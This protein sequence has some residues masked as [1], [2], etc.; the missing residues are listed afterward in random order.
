MNKEKTPKIDAIESVKEEIIKY[1]NSPKYKPQ[2]L[3]G[4]AS[5][6][7]YDRFS[8]RQAISELTEEGVILWGKKNCYFLPQSL[9]WRRGKIQGHPRGYGFFLPEGEGEDIFISPG[10]LNGAWHGDTVWLKPKELKSRRQAEERRQRGQVAFIIKR[11]HGLILGQYEKR[12]RAGIVYPLEKRINQ[13][14]FIR[15]GQGKR[16]KDGD[17]VLAEIDTWPEEGRSPAYGK[18]KEIITHL[19]QKKGDTLITVKKFGL[20][21]EFAPNVLLA[22]QKAAK[23]GLG[24]LEQLKNREDLREEFILTIDGLDARDL[25]DALS[26]TKTKDGNR[27]LGVHIADVAHYVPLNSPLDKEAKERGT[28]VYFPNLVLPMLPPELS[29]GICSLN[30]NEDRLALSCIMEINPKGEIINHRL[31][32]SIIRV[33]HRLC[34]EDINAALE[35]DNQ[36]ALEVLAPCLNMLRDLW[37]LR[38]ALLQRRKAKGSLNFE[39]P[40]CKVIMNEEDEI[41]EVKKQ[42]SRLGESLIEEAMLAANQTVAEAF[43]RLKLPFIYRVHQPCQGDKLFELNESLKM[44]NYYLPGKGGKPNSKDMQELLNKVKGKPE[45]RLVSTLLLRSMDHAFYSTEP[46]GHFALAF[47]YY[48]H[49]TAPIRR[50]PDLAIHRQIKAWL[51]GEKSGGTEEGL[52]FIASHSSGRERLAEKAEREITAI[53]CCRYLED[54]IGECFWGN[55]SGITSYGLY[56]E[57]DTGIE[58]LVRIGDIEDDYYIFYEKE[59]CLKGKKGKTYRLGDRVKVSIARVDA[60]LITIDLFLMPEEAENSC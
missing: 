44:L 60:S 21:A 37:A 39:F 27:L 31:T 59:Y 26:L 17:T 10:D 47:E 38:D 9:G 52:A 5:A 57:M 36:Q 14:I 22:A 12:N 32:E 29:N 20:E 48:S 13:P 55:I 11:A 16:A 18:I 53:L 51:I 4:L 23:N 1:F 6:L 8:L 41:I 30:V 2:N 46:L 24:G 25:D 56:V 50:Y 19:G 42:Y 28:S 33:K 54:K 49:F 45:E 40:E 34:Y 35:E 7:P 3:R 58:G 15:P 43:A